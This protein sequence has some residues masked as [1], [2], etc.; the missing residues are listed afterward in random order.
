MKDFNMPHVLRYQNEEGKRVKI[1]SVRQITLENLYS[2]VTNP[3]IADENTTKDK[4]SLIYWG[5]LKDPSTLYLANNY[6]SRCAI[7]LDYDKDITIADFIESFGNQFKYYI[8]TSWSHSSELNKF[9]VIIPLSS[10]FAMNEGIKNAILSKF[11]G[12]DRSTCDNR[13]FYIP[14]KRNEEYQWHVSNGPVTSVFEMFGDLDADKYFDD[15]FNESLNPKKL[16]EVKVSNSPKFHDIVLES[17]TRELDT[18]PRVTT[19]DRYVEIRRLLWKMLKK[20][21]NSGNFV[22][23]VSECTSLIL[24]HTNDKAIRALCNSS[25]RNARRVR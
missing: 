2:F 23:S 8:Y 20:I 14:C 24:N 10:P 6:G 16:E 13:G 22:F 19:G 15:L 12:V 5:C 21:D 18:I 17:I 25:A 1:E 7:L 11:T 4:L 3:L 9:R